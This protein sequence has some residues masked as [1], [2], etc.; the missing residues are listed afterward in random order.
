MTADATCWQKFTLSNYVFTFL[1]PC[2]DVRCDFQE[3]TIF[4][5]V[6]ICRGF[7][8]YLCYLCP[9][10]FL[11]QMMF[12]LCNSNKT[13]VTSGAGTAYPSGEPELDPLPHS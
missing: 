10:R 9:T 1:V 3:K 5:F 13:G 11:Y 12:V 6:W 8:F 4:R 2:C 7:M